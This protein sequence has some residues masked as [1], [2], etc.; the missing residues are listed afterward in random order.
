MPIFILNDAAGIG[1]SDL[2]SGQ[3]FVDL[4]IIV[5]DDG[6]GLNDPVGGKQ[7]VTYG[8]T[9]S[10]AP[11]MRLD[12]LVNTVF[13]PDY[14]A[15][16]QNVDIIVIA[17]LSGF[18]LD[19]GTSFANNGTALP[20]AGSGLP[21]ASLNTT[22]NC[23]VIYDTQQ[24]ICVARDG[25]DGDID[26]PISN[27]VVLYHEFSHAFRIA[28]NTLLALTSEC[29]PSSPEEN[30]AI[31]DENDLRTD[32]AN[33]QGIAPELR[34]P[35]IHCG[36]VHEDCSSCCIIATVVSRSL[37]SPQ[38]QF[39]RS[40][41]DHFVRSTEVGYAFFE[42]FFRDY[43][44][45]SPQVCTIMARNPNIPG[46]LLE[47]YI[48]PLLDFWKVM[49]ER[50]DKCFSDADL[51]A[52]FIR[53]HRD[54][55]QAESRL[56]ALHRTVVYWLNQNS[57]DS[58][59]PAELITLLRDRAWPSEHIQWALVAPVRIYHDLLTLYLDDADE[60][61]IGREFNRALES[62]APEVP[63]SEVWASLP[64]EQVV[65]ELEF[66]GNALLQSAGNKKRF[67]DRLRDRFHGITSIGA[68]LNGL[69]K[70]VGGAR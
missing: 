46:H 42:Q 33:R 50:S 9:L 28:T 1:S 2:D 3:A 31:I 70:L 64:E 41:R 23:L 61:M 34:D 39:L 58:G 4:T 37:T 30:A 63:I 36:E 44:S 11:Q 22:E 16:P 55:A 52:A 26:L 54:R 53:H 38:V 7:L 59:V 66:C 15:G 13:S 20:P 68:V 51:G 62:W 47:G 6:I 49:I 24:T 21:G 45:F 25:T 27:P 56:D 48:N 43:Y 57:N 14:G 60:E 29:D 10:G 35:G 32:I 19:D 40:V 12:T 17:G 18:T 69:N 8:R 5:N 65:K 67:H